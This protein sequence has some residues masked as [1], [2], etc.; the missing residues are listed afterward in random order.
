MEAQV[1]ILRVCAF[2]CVYGQMYVQK[3]RGQLR[4]HH[5]AVID[6]LFKG[7]F[8]WDG[9]HWDLL[10]VIGSPLALHTP[11]LDKH[12]LSWQ[13]FCEGALNSDPRAWTA[14]N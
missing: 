3:A 8:H 9:F 7:R 6:L 10:L 11:A 4:C 14:C 1:L 2:M 12:G 5:L 13:G